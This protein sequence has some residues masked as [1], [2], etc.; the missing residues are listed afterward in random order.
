MKPG[1]DR[2]ARLLLRAGV[3]C[4]MALLP[5][6]VW[7]A[8][9]NPYG[10]AKYL[11]SCAAA[12]L[13]LAGVAFD[14]H[15]V[16]R[17]LASIRGVPAAALAALCGTVV[18]ATVVAGDPRAALLGSYPGYEAGLV[19]LGAMVVCGYVATAA[20]EA[21]LRTTARLSSVSLSAVGSVA[22]V[23]WLAGFSGGGGLAASLGVGST[24]GN[25]S[26]LGLW[27]AVALPFALHAARTDTVRSWRIAGM[28]ATGLGAAALLLSVSRGAL[29]AVVAAAVAWALL[30]GVFAGGVRRRALVFTLACVVAAAS[31][32]VVLAARPRPDTAAGR[33][34]VWRESVP[35]IAERPFLGF[36]LSGY[37]RAYAARTTLP[38]ADEFGRD[39][40]LADPHNVVISTALSAGPLAAGLLSV[41]VVSTGLGLWRARSEHPEA[42]VAGAALAAG[43]VGLQF[44]FLTLETGP[45]LFAALALAQ[46]STTGGP[47]PVASA[48]SASAVR[49]ARFALAALLL[50]SLATTSL[51]GRILLADVAVREGFAR[52]GS[53]AAASAEAFAT[54]QA[55]APFDPNPAWARGVA[56][57]G[58][59]AG[60]DHT[61]VLAGGIEALS[62]A[63]ELRPGEHRIARDEGDLYAAALLEGGDGA[64]VAD[65]AIR[66]YDRAEALAPTDPLVYLGR[67]GV[68]LAVGA[69]EQAVADLERAVELSPELRVG[70]ANLALARAAIGDGDGAEKA[71][72]RAE[73]PSGDADTP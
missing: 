32:G 34:A 68:Y 15:A 48:P 6:A 12:A 19:A 50:A 41:L 65:A 72:R 5:L 55:R 42:A 70:W 24:L 64:E 69:N 8:A 43:I 23:Q 51:A 13:V 18:L 28:L 56:A 29:V 59:M 61:R 9:N 16:S 11:L 20:L 17:V 71:A 53:D 62:Y 39:R 10:P 66:A 57:R 30:T 22:C 49:A 38:L 40:P 35:M 33:V 2:L 45:V 44:H 1:S 67:G 14:R 7:P 3:V 54:A 31:W 46:T 52:A 25:P 58:A 47:S 63:E 73:V 21:P 26:N 36:G 4:A 60:E 27:C 37:G